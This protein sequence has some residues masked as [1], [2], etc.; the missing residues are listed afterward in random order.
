MP[1]AVQDA[2]KKRSKDELP[3]FYNIVLERPRDD[4]A[5]YDVLFVD[6]ASKVGD[7]TFLA[8]QHSHCCISPE[9]GLAALLGLA[10][11]LQTSASL[12]CCRSVLCA[13]V[14][15]WVSARVTQA[16]LSSAAWVQGAFASRMSHSC[17]PNCH[18]VVMAAAGKLTIALYTLR[19]VH[20]RPHQG[21]GSKRPQHGLDFTV[22]QLPEVHHG[23]N[24]MLACMPRLSCK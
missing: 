2:I 8:E 9:L 11:M 3:D 20:A 5:G 12:A 21:P 18:A 4:P 23:L 10:G 15:L 17:T 16:Q 13:S 6:A 19:Q 14:H 1:V 24:G 7:K 22:I